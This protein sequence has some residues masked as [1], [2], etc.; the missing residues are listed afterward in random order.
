M[1]GTTGSGAVV[2]KAPNK[3]SISSAKDGAVRSQVFEASSEA[4]AS[5]KMGLVAAPRVSRLWSALWE[6]A[7]SGYGWTSC[8][9][10]SANQIC[11]NLFFFGFSSDNPGD[12]LY[13]YN[14]FG[15]QSASVSLVFLRGFEMESKVVSLSCPVHRQYSFIDVPTQDC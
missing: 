10:K 8:C 4:R 9:A 13:W 5:V 3:G 11:G 6:G 1:M 2:R 12:T 7:I 14:G 15:W